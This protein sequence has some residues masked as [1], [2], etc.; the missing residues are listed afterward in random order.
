MIIP[1][2][3]ERLEQFLPFLRPRY[4]IAPDTGGE[5]GIQLFLDHLLQIL[6]D[7]SLDAFVE[8]F[9]LLSED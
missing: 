6:N 9:R 4:H 2:A 7:E 8:L 3:S 5:R 1:D